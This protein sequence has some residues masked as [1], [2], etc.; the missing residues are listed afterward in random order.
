MVNNT[1]K[2]CYN[3]GKEIVIKQIVFDN[4]EEYINTNIGKSSC[5]GVAFV[6][7][8]II[9]FQITPYKGNNEVDSWREKINK[10]SKIK[11]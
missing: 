4:A 3:C 6:V 10:P 1:G 7:R 2:I 11:N 5:C 9:S 8:P